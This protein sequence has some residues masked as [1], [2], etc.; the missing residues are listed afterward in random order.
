MRTRLANQFAVWHLFVGAALATNVGL[1]ATLVAQVKHNRDRAHVVR[2]LAVGWNGMKKELEQGRI[3]ATQAEAALQTARGQAITQG[4]IEALGTIPGLAKQIHELKG[5]K[6]GLE[7]QVNDANA[8][9]EAAASQLDA[10][11][12]SLEANTLLLQG[13]RTHVTAADGELAAARRQLEDEKNAH[14]ETNRQLIAVRAQLA[15]DKAADALDN[16]ELRETKAQLEKAQKRAAALETGLNQ[17]NATVKA[18]NDE[19]VLTRQGNVRLLAQIEALKAALPAGK[20]ESESAERGSVPASGGATAPATGH[21]D[22]TPFT[23][24]VA[25]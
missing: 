6:A 4:Q 2:E 16:E 14:V 21:S 20:A 11:N 12:R 23:I 8:K 7:Q 19:L 9:A 17:S 13:A 18:K 5:E 25:V 24:P 10:A 3:A 1:L 22:E 15:E